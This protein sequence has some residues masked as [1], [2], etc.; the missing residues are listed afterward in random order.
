M[1][2]SH[3]P[4]PKALKSLANVK[5]VPFWMDDKDRPE[6]T[7]ALTENITADLCIIGAGFTGLWAAL[8][9]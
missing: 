7:P 4:S 6:P 8:L 1:S 2:F 3:V 9:A 5:L